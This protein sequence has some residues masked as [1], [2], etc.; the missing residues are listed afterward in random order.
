MT[1]LCCDFENS[2]KRS[3]FKIEEKAEIIRCCVEAKGLRNV[4]ISSFDGLL[5]DFCQKLG[6]GY[7]IRGLRTITDFEYEQQIHSVN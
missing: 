1:N 7:I 6:A 4:T 3:F 2:A 5:I